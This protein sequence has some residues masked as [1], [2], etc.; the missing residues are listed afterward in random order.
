MNGS[1]LK[2]QT[3]APDSEDRRRPAAE[4]DHHAGFDP[5]DGS[6]SGRLLQASKYIRGERGCASQ[7]CHVR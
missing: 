4:P 6:L 5:F 2:K 1:S 3:D 7:P